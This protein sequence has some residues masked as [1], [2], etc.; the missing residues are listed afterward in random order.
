MDRDEEER[1]AN[2]SDAEYEQHGAGI[3]RRRRFRGLVAT[4]GCFTLFV[5]W[6]VFAGVPVAVMAWAYWFAS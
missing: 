6:G 5:A 2:M 4:F 1:I 3:L